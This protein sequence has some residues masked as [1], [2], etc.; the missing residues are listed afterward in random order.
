MPIKTFPTETKEIVSL[1]NDTVRLEFSPTGHRYKIFHNGVELF[2]TKGVTTVIGIV[3]K[4]E[5]LQWSANMANQTWIEGLKGQVTYD[6][7]LIS[8]LSKE[9]PNAWRT[10][11][12]TAGDLGTIVHRVIEQWILADIKRQKYYENK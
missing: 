5:L 7:L 11:R 12:D 9:A 4:P 8:R 2:G 1:Y 3:D 6:E 10:R